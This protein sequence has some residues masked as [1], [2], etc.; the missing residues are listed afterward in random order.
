M[1]ACLVGSWTVVEG[2]SEG[3]KGL[4]RLGVLSVYLARNK[5]EILQLKADEAEERKRNQRL[6]QVGAV[7]L[8]RIN[9]RDALSWKAVMGGSVAPSRLAEAQSAI[10]PNP[11]RATL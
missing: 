11:M 1:G 6:A 2:I 5:A 8:A 4:T 3:R 7:D 10:Q 9:W